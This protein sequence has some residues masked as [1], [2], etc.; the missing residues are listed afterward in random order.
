MIHFIGN[1]RTDNTLKQSTVEQ[2][3]NYFKDHEVIALDTETQGRNPHT[4][5]II[6]LQ[7]GDSDNQYVIDCRSID[8]LKFKE[9]IESKTII[10]HNAK[11]DYKFLKKAGI[12]LDKIYD[13]MLAE[14]VLYC[15][16]E[17]YGYGLDK[18]VKRYIDIDLSKETRCDFF[19]V[20]DNELTFKQITY[21]ALDVTYLHTIR[22]Q[23][24]K[25]AARFDLLYCINLENEAVKALADIEYNGMILDRDKW[26]SIATS[27][28]ESLKQCEKELDDLIL[29][30]TELSRSYPPNGSVT[31]FGEVERQLNINYSSP[32]QI[33]KLFT[34]LGYPVASTDDR[35]LT[36]LADKHPIFKTLQKYRESAKRVSTY[37]ESFLKYINP[38][39]GRVHTDFW[40]IRNTGRVSSGS[41]QMNAPNLQNI[42]NDNTTRNCFIAR[43]GYKW[44]S[45]DYSQQELRLMA[46]GSGEPGFIACLNR[47]ED[48]HCFAGS[49]MFRREITAKDKALR[50][51]AKTINF[52]KPYGMG[53]N[54]L[55]DTL[56]IPLEEAEELFALYAKEFPTL[57]TWLDSQAKFALDH[58]Y[59]T[60]FA[61]CKRKRWYP[62]MKR[63]KYLRGIVQF[64]DKETWREILKVE[65]QTQRN[66]MNQ[67]IQGTGADITKEALIAVRNLIM[68]YNK[69]EA[70][71]AFL[72]C[73]VHDQ[74][75][76]EVKEEYAEEF[77]QKMEQLM[78]EAG[79]KYVSQVSMAVD[80]TITDCWTK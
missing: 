41:E 56:Q 25:D 68:E 28:E 32:S 79:N 12:I 80:T 53:P 10:L 5:K 63:A 65:G 7:L 70:D 3:L 64:G 26:M 62:D 35:T 40:Q 48:L 55:A 23:Q 9:L 33:K 34:T 46:D 71:T 49:M 17:N 4:K 24:L 72:I 58:M 50:S 73:T 77:A 14:C 54:K 52:G 38:A 1:P 66:G 22:E 43:R 30:D 16:I 29:N 31:L 15:G 2:C 51:K 42:P 18:L 8:I 74:I 11:F 36:T 60:T 76:V 39:T 6:S 78:I 57:N 37:G 13:T 69:K 61:P 67:P 19:K 21:G 27:Y 75:D 47:G 20:N 59:S 45:S 44:I